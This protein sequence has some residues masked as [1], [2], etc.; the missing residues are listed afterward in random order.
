MVGTA[1]QGMSEI[2]KDES[3]KFTASVLF[4]GGAQVGPILG[5]SNEF[6]STI[7]DELV[8]TTSFSGGVGPKL[9]YTQQ[10]AL[11]LQAATGDKYGKAAQE[12]LTKVTGSPITAAT[13]QTML[14]GTE[15][16]ANAEF[17]AM[18]TLGYSG[19]LRA[20]IDGAQT[21][22][23][24]GDALIWSTKTTETPT[25]AIQ[26]VG[27]GSTNLSDQTVPNDVMAKGYPL[28][29]TAGW[30]KGLGLTQESG[31]TQG[32]ALRVYTNFL[33][34]THSSALSA[35]HVE[36]VSASAEAAQAAT[37]EM[38]TQIVTFLVTKGAVLSIADESVGTV[39]E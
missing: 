28:S 13:A 26:I 11:M 37:T 30:L 9:G 3:F 35:A 24:S 34:G 6:G 10:E 14:G 5:Y 19:F 33:V 27:N 39:V 23:D 7:K 38:Q 31:P 20:F 16:Q 4:A 32:A 22:L 1:A 17:G 15:A 29:G 2:Y 18:V 36:G 8:G 21:V 25:L 12:H